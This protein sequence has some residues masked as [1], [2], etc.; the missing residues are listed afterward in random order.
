MLRLNSPPP[1]RSSGTGWK[2]A[3]VRCVAGSN[4]SLRDLFCKCVVIAHPKGPFLISSIKGE[5]K[6]KN[7]CIDRSFSY[8]PAHVNEPDRFK[9]FAPKTRVAQAL[10]LNFGCP[11]LPVFE[12]FVTKGPVTWVALLAGIPSDTAPG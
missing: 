12:K 1:S 3:R 9:P 7:Y 8:F 11:I 2:L 4:T 5:I 10:R 6:R